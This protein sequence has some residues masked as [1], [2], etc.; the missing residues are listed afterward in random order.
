MKVGVGKVD[1]T[2]QTCELLTFCREEGRGEGEG[3]VKDR[4]GESGGGMG[5]WTSLHRH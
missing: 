3:G 4:G 2:I 5:R 1:V